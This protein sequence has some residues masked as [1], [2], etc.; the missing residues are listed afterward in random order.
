M[1]ARPS[2]R[3]RSC[4]VAWYGRSVRRA[5]RIVIG[6]AVALALLAVG[7]LFG[8]TGVALAVVVALIAWLYQWLWLP[9]IAHAAFEAGN[10]ARARRRY[11]VLGVLAASPAR[12]RAALLSRAACHVALGQPALADELTAGL[13]ELDVAERAV[14]L[15]NRACALLAADPHA[16]LALVDEASALRPDVPALQHTRGLA[17]LAVGR[18]DDA[19]AVLD[20]MRAGGELAPRLEAERCRDLARAWT[21]KGEPAYA[22]DYRLRAAAIAG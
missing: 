18:L 21:Q 9:R 14:L 22:D 17:L 16:A 11:R 19:I 7:S 10:F 15:N 2:D 6:T 20:K 3:P 4:G 8:G 12:Q 5:I 13:V 1:R